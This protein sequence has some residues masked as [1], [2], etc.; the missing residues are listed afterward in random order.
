MRSHFV[1]TGA[2]YLLTAAALGLATR[3]TPV[4]INYTLLIGAI[5]LE[6]II[7]VVS[8]NKI[9]NRNLYLIVKGAE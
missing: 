6:L 2:T 5:V 1:I 4:T 9:A 8:A 3:F 7:T